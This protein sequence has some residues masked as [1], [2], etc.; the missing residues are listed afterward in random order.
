MGD[1]DWKADHLGSAG[2]IEQRVQCNIGLDKRDIGL[3][4][5]EA[6]QNLYPRPSTKSLHRGF[7]FFIFIIV[8]ITSS[9]VGEI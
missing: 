1:L 9:M 6:K 8:R 7:R 4:N 3:A 5:V 2:G